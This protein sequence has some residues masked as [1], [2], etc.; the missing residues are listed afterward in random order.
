MLRAPADKGVE[1]VSYA[2]LF[3]NS[4]V[5]RRHVAPNLAFE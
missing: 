3:G 2:G 5:S 1:V 4:G